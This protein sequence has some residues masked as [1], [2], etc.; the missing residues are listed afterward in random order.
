MTDSKQE[1]GVKAGFDATD[2]DPYLLKDPEAMSVIGSE[3]LSVI[4]PR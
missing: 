1:N 3:A 4:S 2:L